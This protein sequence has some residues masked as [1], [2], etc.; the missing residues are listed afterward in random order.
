MSAFFA[1]TRDY[2]IRDTEAPLNEG[3]SD[4]QKRIKAMYEEV[5]LTLHGPDHK[6]LAVLR[7]SERPSARQDLGRVAAQDLPSRGSE[8]GAQV[9]PFVNGPLLEESDSRQILFE[10]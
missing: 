4:K 7:D 2:G 1:M 3:P 9:V 8:V 6:A 5:Q 10:Q